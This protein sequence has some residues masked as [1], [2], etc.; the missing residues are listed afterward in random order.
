MIKLAKILSIDANQVVLDLETK[1]QCSDC[2]SH[3]SD[4]FLDFIFHKKNQN[5]IKV[6]LNTSNI[7]K[8]H[9]Q[10]HLV[11]SNSFFQNN[12][13]T[14][15][16][17]GIKF[18]ESQL[19]KLALL[20]YGLPIIFIVVFLLLGYYSFSLLSLNDDFGGIIGL[21]TGLILAKFIIKFNQETFKPQVEFFK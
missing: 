10:A 9:K 16:I 11:D 14:N 4:G 7:N 18:K 8:N 15:D 13:Q 5:H 19:Y 21:L 6:A 2:Q 3:C 1:S 12:Y 17:V 20:L